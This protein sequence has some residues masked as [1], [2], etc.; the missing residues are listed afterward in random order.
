MKTNYTMK[1]LNNLLKLENL[2]KLEFHQPSHFV[3]NRENKGNKI[4]ISLGIIRFGLSEEYN[5]HNLQ[6]FENKIIFYLDLREYFNIPIEINYNYIK[7]LYV[8]FLIYNNY[9]FNN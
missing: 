3:N 4:S 2:F 7:I 6:F 5:F 1:Q 9:H 8:K